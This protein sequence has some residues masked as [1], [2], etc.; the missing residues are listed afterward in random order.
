[1]SVG[2]LAKGSKLEA[3]SWSLFADYDS[4]T[5]ATFREL[6]KLLGVEIKYCDGRLNYL[7]SWTTAHLELWRGMVH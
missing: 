1:M 5:Y 6:A 3:W 2:Y 7:H 4:H